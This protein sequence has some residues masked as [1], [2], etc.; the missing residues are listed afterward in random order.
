MFL[1]LFGEVICNNIMKK[2]SRL[3][4]IN[5]RILDCIKGVIMMMYF[6]K[7]IVVKYVFYF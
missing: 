4:E 6:F 3:V 2:M 1:N 5:F 7:K